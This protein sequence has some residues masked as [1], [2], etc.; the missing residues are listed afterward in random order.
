MGRPPWSDRLTVEE[1]HGLVVEELMRKGLF[2]APNG[3]NCAVTWTNGDGIELFRV[4]L[5]L[6]AT[7]PGRIALILCY[8]GASGYTPR[9]SRIEYGVQVTS[10][11][12]RFGG[13]RY[14][15]LCPVVRQ[16]IRCGQRVSKLYLPVGRGMFGCRKCHNLTYTSCRNKTLDRLLEDPELIRQ[17]LQSSNFRKKMLGVAAYTEAFRRVSEGKLPNCADDKQRCEI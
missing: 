2:S 11:P 15:F 8:D 3:T 5:R 17:N 12:C 6:V 13:Q 1:C 4:G 14:W 9:G 10:T 7:T 16:G